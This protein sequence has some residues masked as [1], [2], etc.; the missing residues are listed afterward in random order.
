MAAQYIWSRVEGQTVNGC[1]DDLTKTSTALT[2]GRLVGKDGDGYV[3]HATT[4]VK[5][6]GIAMESKSSSDATTAPILIDYVKRSDILRAKVDA[7]TVSQTTEGELVDIHANGGL[8]VG[9]STNDDAYVLRR[10]VYASDAE[11]LV[12]LQNTVF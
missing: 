7:G 6:L 12:T 8:D 3:V 1:K 4:G 5:V 11:I 2:Q 10:G 9:A